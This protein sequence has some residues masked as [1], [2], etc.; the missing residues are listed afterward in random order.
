MLRKQQIEAK[1]NTALAPVYLEVVDESYRHHVLPGS[2][3]HFNVVIVSDR[4][5]GERI[6][7]RHRVIYTLLADELAN[8]VH[9]LAL[10]TYTPKEWEALE[11]KV[12]TSPPCRGG[13][14]G[15][16]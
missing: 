2:E 5:V 1:L 13:G 8:G 3:S 10:H 16:A 4:F 12:L 7:A 6:L 14:G 9:A 11:D 15:L